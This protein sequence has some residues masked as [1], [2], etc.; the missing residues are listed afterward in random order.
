MKVGTTRLVATTRLVLTLGLAAGPSITAGHLA[1]ILA[2]GLMLAPACALADSGS[3]GSGSGGSGSSGGGSGSSGSGGS[4]SGGSSGSGSGSSGSGSGGSGS[5]DDISDADEGEYTSND[6]AAIT[7][8]EVSS[9]G[10]RIRYSDGSSERIDRGFYEHKSADGR[11]IEMRRATGADISR[12]RAITKR[13]DVDS[14]RVPDALDGGATV[15]AARVVGNDVEIV[16]SNG[17]RETLL[18]GSYQLKDAYGRTVVKRAG[19]KTD[20]TRMSNAASR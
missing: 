3:G 16:Y 12:L 5:S 4:G 13:V 9:D 1:A 14:V 8:I 17:W 6:H 2:A 20:L 11:T 15:S 7:R 19:L 10:V 18:Q